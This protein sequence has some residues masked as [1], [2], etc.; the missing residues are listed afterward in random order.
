VVFLVFFTLKGGGGMKK[1]GKKKRCERVGA[2]NVCVF[3][4]VLFSAVP[5][6]FSVVL[7]LV[8]A[9]LMSRCGSWVSP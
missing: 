5:P 4:F 2:R 6:T 9:W 7:P 8:V 3:F 1:G